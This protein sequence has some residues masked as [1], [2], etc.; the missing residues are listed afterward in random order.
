MKRF[1]KLAGIVIVVAGI[2]TG[3]YLWFETQRVAAQTVSDLPTATVQRGTLAATVNAAGNIA[4][5]Q[6]VDLSFEQSGTVNKVDVQVG[7]QVKSG[8]VLAELDGASLT[9]QLQN[10]QVNL[11]NAQDQ[12]AQ[13]KNPNTQQDIANAQA[14][15]DSAKASYNKL[16][17]GASAADIVAAQAN[18]ASAQAA[19]NAAVKTAG[20]G[21]NALQVA[22]AAVES[23]QAALQTAQAAYDRVKS[24]PNIGMM[25]QST[26]LQQATIAY[27]SALASYQQL[28]ATSATNAN[29]TVQQ[30]KAQ[31]QQAQTNLT[32]LKNQVTQNDVIASQAL[33][34][35]AQNNLDKLLAGPDAPTLN[36]AQNAVDQ[37]QIA[38]K[39]AQLAVQQA[40]IVAPF[41]GVV[42][43]IN[44]T[45]GQSSAAG[46]GA[47]A[48]QLA[49]LN[50]LEI[51]VNM[52]EV[53]VTKAKLGQA[54]QISLDAL[55]NAQLDG[56]VTAIAPAGTLTQG[57]VNYPVT[58]QVTNPPASVKSA[59]TANLNII[60][61]Q[62]DNV[63]LVPNRAVKTAASGTATST[64]PA[65]APAA[66]TRIAPSS[67]LTGTRSAGQNAGAGSGSNAAANGGA[68][69]PAR[70]Q[71]VIMLQDGKQVQVA[72]VTG[73]SNDTMTEIVS[74]LNEGDVVL[75]TSTTTTAP[76]GGGGLG[77]PG[78]GRFG[79]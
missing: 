8:Q 76:A 54:A 72:V 74:G 13:A 61:Q 39:Q 9:L 19:Y 46:S 29:S 16:V 63:L 50:H 73:L 71:Y 12:L 44:I 67:A 48:I 58:V 23:A 36:L 57:V 62:Q 21:D 24:D 27:Q 2:T 17:A 33:V 28:Q 47:T 7:D 11:K 59:M 32:N 53:D 26:A 34:T 35:E 14:A 69:R 31:L 3:A 40:Q 18:V 75:L 41:D 5:T 1:L 38:L 77:I 60:V 25:A 10:A 20:A 30:A 79:G 51:V 45:P 55:P 64:G 66:A 78:A 6:Q 15:L 49:D 56:T 68:P 43:A 22:A 42:T 52:A 37:A 65:T 4:P 70:Q